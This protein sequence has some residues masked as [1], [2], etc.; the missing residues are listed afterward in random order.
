[1]QQIL[2]K[3]I[4]AVAGQFKPPL[5]ENYMHAAKNFRIPYWDWAMKLP[6]GQESFPGSIASPRIEVTHPVRGRIEVRNP[7]HRY[8]FRSIIPNPTD[9]PNHPVCPSL[10]VFLSS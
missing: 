3:H 10:K 7:L 8:D 9:F 6:A 5:Q 2:Y 1:M 4:Q